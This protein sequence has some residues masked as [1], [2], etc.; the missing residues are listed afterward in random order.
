LL[1]QLNHFP[2]SSTGPSKI[3][4]SVNETSDLGLNIDELSPI[5]FEQPNIQV[6]FGIKNFIKSNIA[7]FNFDLYSTS[8]T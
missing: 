6:N 3:V 8:G 5:L 7:K 1:T 4:S 2:F